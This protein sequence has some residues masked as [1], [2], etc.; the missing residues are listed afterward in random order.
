[1]I[2]DPTDLFGDGGPWPV[3][4]HLKTLGSKVTGETGAFMYAGKGGVMSKRIIHAD[5]EKGV[6]KNIC[7]GTKKTCDDYSQEGILASKNMLVLKLNY[8][9]AMTG[10]TFVAIAS[11]D[12]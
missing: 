10:A 8:S 12:K 6:L 1:M 7:W 2:A 4:I 3:T 5:C 11:R 9:N